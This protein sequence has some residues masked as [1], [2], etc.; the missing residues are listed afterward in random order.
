MIE[1]IQD[2]A[3]FDFLYNHPD[4]RAE[5]SWVPDPAGGETRQLVVHVELCTVASMPE[6]LR[7]WWVV[8]M[9]KRMSPLLKAD[10]TRAGTADIPLFA[11]SGDGLD[12]TIGS[13]QNK[14]SALR[15]L[16]RSPEME[17]FYQGVM[18]SLIDPAN[19]PGMPGARDGILYMLYTYAIADGTFIPLYIGKA[20]RNGKSRKISMNL[21]SNDAYGRWGYLYSRHM[22][23]LSNA[24]F[25]LSGQE[26]S[27]APRAIVDSHQKE[28]WVPILFGNPPSNPPR[29]QFPVYF[30]AFTWGPEE[31]S[32]LCIGAPGSEQRKVNLS[33]DQ[34]ERLLVGAG[35]NFYAENLNKNWGKEEF[36]KIFSL[37]E[38]I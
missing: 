29:L 10:L 26:I 17:T 14:R 11:T 12:V 37:L 38:S 23:D 13:I 3:L 30:H 22:G 24:Y 9:A 1:P 35:S 27:D 34:L 2:A 25:R 19:E 28:S 4:A 15:R 21:T 36:C 18:N 6:I 5:F 33:T 20:E 16:L 31:D 7:A 8:F 32:L